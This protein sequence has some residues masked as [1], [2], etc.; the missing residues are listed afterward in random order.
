MGISNKRILINHITVLPVHLL[1]C[2]YQAK[3]RGQSWEN[4]I[5]Q[6]RIDI[7]GLIDESSS[8]K[9]QI[10]EKFN[11]AYKRAR[12]DASTEMGI[13][14]NALPEI[15]PFTLKQCLDEEFWPA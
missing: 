7:K 8:L 9:H 11:L 14:K 4:T 10:E 6:Q 1:K 13:K 5:E 2:K 15:Y 12:L 3:K